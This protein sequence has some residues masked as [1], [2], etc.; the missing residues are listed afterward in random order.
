LLDKIEELEADI[1]RLVGLLDR[2]LDITKEIL[3]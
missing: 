1:E 2:A 3:P